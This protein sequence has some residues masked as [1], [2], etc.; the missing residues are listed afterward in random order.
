MHLN[1]GDFLDLNLNIVNYLKKNLADMQ[2]SVTLIFFK[3]K[4]GYAYNELLSN[5][6]AN[7]KA[8]NPKL[9]LEIRT[10][11]SSDP[12][13]KEYG[14]DAAPAIIL[15]GKEK[16][17]VRYFGLPLSNELTAFLL[18]IKDISRGGPQ[19]SKELIEKIKSVSFPV[20]LQVFTTP[21]CSFC[22]QAVKVA[23]DFA[24]INQ[25]I[26]SDMVD[27][28]TFSQLAKKFNVTNVP[29]TVINGKTEIVGAFPSEVVLKKILDSQKK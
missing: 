13:A 19:L 11:S 14:V 26:V 3:P 10:L 24:M 27:T 6:S 20:H 15:E 1:N 16:R 5:L 21:D 2:G 28:T 12:K 9:S 7:I 18:D 4:E 29:T 8:I 22:P 23:H 25:K 17:F